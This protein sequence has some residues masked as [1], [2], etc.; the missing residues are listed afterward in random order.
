[1]KKII[2]IWEY[3]EWL[4]IITIEVSPY[5]LD[6]KNELI[7][8]DSWWHKNKYEMGLFMWP[9]GFNDMWKTSIFEDYDMWELD[10]YPDDDMWPWIDV[11][12]V[13][14]YIDKNWL[15]LFKH[16]FTY[17][18]NFSN[19]EAKVELFGKKFIINNKWFLRPDND[20]NWL[21]EVDTICIGSENLY[22]TYYNYINKKWEIVNS[23]WWEL[24]EF[25]EYNTDGNLIIIK[26]SNSTFNIVN[27]VNWKIFDGNEYKKATYISWWKK[28][29]LVNNAWFD[30][31]V[32]SKFEEVSWFMKYF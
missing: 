19:T 15:I 7:L 4:A 1:M 9:S 8:P 20:K 16:N 10:E 30:I 18:S 13:Y 24:E 28:V 25:S 31:V 5:F 27:K 6:N 2:E 12:V 22:Y 29:K 26:Y 14:N 11:P 3:F 17:A 23:K 21:F 32:N